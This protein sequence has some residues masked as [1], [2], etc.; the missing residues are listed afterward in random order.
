MWRG[1]A[2]NRSWRFPR[3]CASPATQSRFICLSC[4]PSARS[5]RYHPA[6]RSRCRPAGTGGRCRASTPAAP[7]RSAAPRPS[8]AAHPDPTAHPHIRPGSGVSRWRCGRGQL[9]VACSTTVEVTHG[10]DGLHHALA[11]TLPVFDIETLPPQQAFAARGP[12]CAG[13]ARRSSPRRTRR[14]APTSGR[15]A[16]RDVMVTVA[17]TIPTH[18]LPCH[19]CLASPG[20]APPRRAMPDPARPCHAC[21][22][23]VRRGGAAYTSLRAARQPNCRSECRDVRCLASERPAIMDQSKRRGELVHRAPAR[24]C[25]G[26]AVSASRPICTAWTR[27]N[28]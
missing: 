20:L 28:C 24:R 2:A 12:W 26:D 5:R 23:S 14:R 17:G 1:L 10:H 8:S 13:I 7:G 11:V 22:A 9:P 4:P 27:P 25:S 6:S 15:S 18:R 21:R 3:R 16:R 19:A